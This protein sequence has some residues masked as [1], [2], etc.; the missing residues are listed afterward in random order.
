MVDLTAFERELALAAL[1]DYR[2]AVE[3][4]WRAI[5]ARYF[6]LEYELPPRTTTRE[7]RMEE[8]E[9]RRDSVLAEYNPNLPTYEAK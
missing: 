3:E 2:R 7:A 8:I 5:S 4:Q 1:A 9:R 6:N